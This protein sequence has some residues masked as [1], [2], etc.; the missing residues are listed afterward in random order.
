[1]NLIYLKNYNIF[2]RKQS[3]KKLH[4]SEQTNKTNSYNLLQAH[5]SV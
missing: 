4:Y 5:S 3:K 1:M 2:V